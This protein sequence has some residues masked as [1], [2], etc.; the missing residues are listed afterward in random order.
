[1]RAPTE[2]LQSLGVAGIVREIDE[3]VG[4]DPQIV[5]EFASLGVI[6]VSRVLPVFGSIADPSG[7][8]RVVHV[9]LAPE[10]IPQRGSFR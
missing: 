10:A 4:I 1:M 2:M 7:Y 5:E 8:P 9:V 3:L 6:D